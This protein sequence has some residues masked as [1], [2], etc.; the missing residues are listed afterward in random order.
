MRKKSRL[1]FVAKA[2]AL[3]WLNLF[4]CN[5]A[6][7][8]GDVAYSTIGGWQVGYREVDTLTGCQAAAHFR[9]ETTITLALIQTG[10]SKNWMVWIS[11]PNWNSWIRKNTEHILLFMPINPTKIWRDP[12]SVG[13]DNQLYLMARTELINSVAD[14]KALAIFDR[15]RRLLTQVNMKDSEAAIKAVVNCVRDHPYAPPAVSNPPKTRT[16]SS[17][18]TAFFVAPNL[19]VTNNHVVKE[20][21]SDIQVR[22]PN[23]EWHTATTRGQDDTNDLAL[24]HTDMENLSVASFRLQSEVG[25]PVAIYGFPYPGL[26]SS[27][28][29]FTMGTPAALNGMNDDSR[30]IQMSAPIQPGNSG[31]PLLDM[32]GSVIG[33]VQSQLSALAMMRFADSVPQNVNFAIQAPILVNFLSTKGVTPKSDSSIVHRDLPPAQVADLAKKFTVEVYCGGTSPE[34]SPP[35]PKS[36]GIPSPTNPTTSLEQQA[37]EFALSIQALWSKPNIEALSSLDALYEDEV[38]YYGKKTKKDAVIKEKRA[39]AQQFPQR[40]YKPR[41][42]ISVWCSN[43]TCA[44]HGLIDFRAVDQV[45]QIVSTGV[46]TFDYQFVMGTRIKIRMENGDVLTRTRTPLSPTS[47]TH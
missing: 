41:E 23:R 42:P 11:N 37:K 27:S 7:A 24:L 29:N 31:G 43:D 1:L 30:F 12:W 38:M 35:P 14:A 39:F 46:A 33:I 36:S 45:A 32:S 19:L 40:E 47:A 28:G 21:G 5:F 13:E 44:V 25:E 22:Y 34:V 18:G 2:A 17:S 10:N 3:L 20:C 9:D 4:F 16:T 6:Q 8:A 26:L 15:N